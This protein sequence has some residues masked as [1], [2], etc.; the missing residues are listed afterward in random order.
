MSQ[1]NFADAEHAHRPEMKARSIR[2]VP[3]PLSVLTLLETRNDPQL[4]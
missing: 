1:I 4:C 3:I 2:T